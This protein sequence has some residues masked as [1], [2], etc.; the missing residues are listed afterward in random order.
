MPLYVC[1]VWRGEPQPR[2]G[3]AL[4]WLRPR[5]LRDLPMPPA[6]RPLIPVLEELL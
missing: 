6:D 5:D 4:R 3:Q 2:E 1:R